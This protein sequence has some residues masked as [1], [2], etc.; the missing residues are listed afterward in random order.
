MAKVKGALMSLDASGTLGRTIV[1]Q[2]SPS[3]V[4]VFPRV[5]PYDPKS[6]G[7]LSIR[8]YIRKG[9][10]YW[11]NIGAPYVAQWNAFVT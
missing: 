1:F 7:Q 11:H 10:Y 4:R 6:I 8:E 9:I 3:C 5:S 2:R